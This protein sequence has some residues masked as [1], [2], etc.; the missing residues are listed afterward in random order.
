[1]ICSQ[2]FDQA[3]WH[4]MNGLDAWHA[5]KKLNG[6]MLQMSGCLKS[7]ILSTDN[8]YLSPRSVDI[9]TVMF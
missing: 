5:C 3:S 4:I 2:M 8:G 1:M 6:K 9:V 7:F